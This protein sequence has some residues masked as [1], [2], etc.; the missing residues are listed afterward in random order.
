[1][2]FLKSML[3]LL[4]WSF[5]CVPFL[6]ADP[7][8][9]ELMGKVMAN[10]PR[11]VAALLDKGADVNYQDPSYGSTPLMMAC[12]YGFTDIA[13]LLL[14]KG[15]DVNRQAKNGSTALI[16]AARQSKELVELLLDK[17]ADVKQISPATA[18]PFTTSVVRVLSGDGTTDIAE[19]LLEKGADVD[20]AASEGRMAGYTPLMM[21]A[22]N[23]NLALVEFLVEHGANVNAQA[24][25]GTTALQKA[26]GKKAKD[27]VA[28]LKKQVAKAAKPAG[29]GKGKKK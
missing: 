26:Q 2:K 5:L 23:G 28:F 12:N 29:K 4:A 9:E 10:E 7:L 21:A 11:A 18:G 20:E 3:P 17:G 16:G 19:L 1:M 6:H 24:A 8:G 14:D 15:A 13:N 25:D 27:V 22:G